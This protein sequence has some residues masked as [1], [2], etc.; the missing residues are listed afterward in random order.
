MQDEALEIVDP[1]GRHN[2]YASRSHLHSHTYLLHK[3][4][5]VLLFNV[6]DKLLLQ[7][8]SKNKDL[9]PGKWDISV[10]GMLCP[11]RIL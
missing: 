3:V 5:H 9:F 6:E 1:D 4:V 2:L 11:A 8:R 7:K 10:E